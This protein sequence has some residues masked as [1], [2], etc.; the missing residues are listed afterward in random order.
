VGRAE[1]I[2]RGFVEA[3]LP[4]A[5]SFA[6][7]RHG[8]ALEHDLDGLTASFQVD[9]P[10]DQDG[11]RENYLVVAS[12]DGYRQIP[13]DWRFVHPETHLDV[14]TAAYPRPLP[15]VA[16]I[17]HGNGL[18]CAPWSRRAY[19]TDDYQG[20]HAGDWGAPSNWQVPRPN[21]TQADTIA[22]MIDRLIVEVRQRTRGRMAPLP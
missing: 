2:A 9:G 15:G 7:K 20:P 3:E 19:A 10:A 21:V 17:F 18:V 6:E 1:L 5:A 22:D 8:I 12:F 11:E 4:A 14:G 13:P 16:S